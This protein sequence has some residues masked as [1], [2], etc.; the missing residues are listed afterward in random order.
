MLAFENVINNYRKEGVTWLSEQMTKI[1]QNDLEGP[2]SYQA[3]RIVLEAVKE[4]NV[5]T[6]QRKA[7]KATEK[8]ILQTVSE[9]TTA[10]VSEETTS[11]VSEATKKVTKAIKEIRQ[12][13]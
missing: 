2:E 4:V 7:L 13:A 12:E 5:H 1:G 3:R 11:T 8:A 6:L 10:T 9:E